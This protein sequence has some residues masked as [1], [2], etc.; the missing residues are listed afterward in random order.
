MRYLAVAEMP[1]VPPR[2][3]FWDSLRH[4]GRTL[5]EWHAVKDS[6]PKPIKTLCGLSYSAE[7]HR[8][9]ALTT[10]SNR[11][12]ACEHVVMTTDRVSTFIAERLSSPRSS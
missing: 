8:T 6:S 10:P 4:R 11:C 12:S 1:R 9:W 2:R 7:A 3:S 5:P